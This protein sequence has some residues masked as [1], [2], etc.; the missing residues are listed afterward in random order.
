MFNKIYPNNSQPFEIREIDGFSDNFPEWRLP[1]I[2]E[3]RSIHDV[4]NIIKNFKPAF[5]LS[6]EGEVINFSDDERSSKLVE[7]KDVNI[8]L[9]RNIDDFIGQKFIIT[10]NDYDYVWQVI[11]KVD[12]S[13]YRCK[14]KSTNSMRNVNNYDNYATF[15]KDIIK[16]NKID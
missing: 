16:S 7:L 3:L 1:T 13:S 14:L 10:T 4:K 8:R 9:V 11:N 6:Q 2:K 12:E 15:N 5:Y